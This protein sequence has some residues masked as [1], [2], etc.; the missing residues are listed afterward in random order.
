MP[1]PHICLTAGARR[2]FAKVDGSLAAVD[3]IA[4]FVPRV[5]HM[6]GDPSGGQSE[7]R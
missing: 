6:V 4:V 7:S 2:P 5:R 1:S 3:A